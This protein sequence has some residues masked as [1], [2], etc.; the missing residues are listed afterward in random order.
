MLKMRKANITDHQFLVRIDS[1]NDGYTVPDEAEMS[2]QEK[3]EHI[4]KIE[5]YLTD[6]N[7]G[8]YIIEDSAFSKPIAMIMYSIANRDSVYP[9]TVFH[10]L[11]QNL[12]QSDGQFMEIFQLWV[13][14]NYRRLGLA[15]KLKLKLEEKAQHHKVDLIYT[16]TEETNTHVIKLNEKIGYKKVRRGPIWDD[17]IRV[18]LIKKLN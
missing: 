18:S 13:H 8:A 3:E 16:H 11:D 15:T 14:P 12:F 4:K 6:S 2:E 5:G 9:W 1:K 10:E 17:V 7:K